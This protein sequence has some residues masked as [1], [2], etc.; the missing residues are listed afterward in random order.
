MAVS[1]LA[2]VTG[3]LIAASAKTRAE[4]DARIAVVRDAIK[5]AVD[6]AVI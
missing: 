3:G 5:L 2:N 6:V 1:A 4:A